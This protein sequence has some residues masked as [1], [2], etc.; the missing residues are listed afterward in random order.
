MSTQNVSFFM[1]KQ[2]KMFIFILLLCGA[3]NKEN[4]IR[5]YCLNFS[6]FWLIQQMTN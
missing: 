6:P 3:V 2:E 1:E 5:S 4:I